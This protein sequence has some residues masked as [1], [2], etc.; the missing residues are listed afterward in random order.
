MRPHPIDVSASF[1]LAIEVT[2]THQVGDDAL[3]SSL[4]DVQEGSHVADAKTRIAGEKQEQIA[5]I[6]E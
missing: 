5:V 2:R 1:S 3:G 4:G 6:C